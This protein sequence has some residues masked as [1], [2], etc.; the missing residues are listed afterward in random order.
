MS[1][2]HITARAMEVKRRAERSVAARRW[3]LMSRRIDAREPA[4]LDCARGRV[5]SSECGAVAPDG[6]VQVREARMR[7]DYRELRTA[8]VPTVASVLAAGSLLLSGEAAARPQYAARE[9]MNCISCHVDPDG[10]GLRHG[11][12][13]SYQR[14]RHAFEVEPKFEE[15]PADPELAKGVRIGSDL[16]ATGLSYDTSDHEEDGEEPSV[17]TPRTYASFAMQGAVYLGFTPADHVVLYYAHDLGASSQKQRDW[18][19]ML[20]GLTSLNLYIK[21]GQMRTPYGLRLDDHSAFTRGMQSSPPGEEGM[22]DVNPRETYP[23]VEVGFVKNTVHAQVSYQDAQG[24]STP[25]FTKFEEKMVNARLGIRAGH[26]FVG[27]SGRY[28]GLGDGDEMSQSTRVG[29]FAMF[30]G[31]KFALLAEVDTGENQFSG[32]LSDEEV[33]GAFLQGEFYL[34]RAVALR[35]DF[36]YMDFT[37]QEFDATI[38]TARRYAAGI[39]WNPIPFVKLTAEGRLVSNSTIS[40]D[41]LDESWGLVYAVFSY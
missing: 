38:R 19:G 1:G 23:G 39:D 11:N 32:S 31:S 30:G 26:L 13:F 14:G 29:A 10:G 6:C 34:S 36:N 35:G 25:N 37:N 4:S 8:V 41:G 15:W 21:A 40:H 17:D 12:G 20:R 3:P 2:S 28:N 7:L 22:M 33:N 5:L 18:Y 16:R 27:A 9:G 24:S